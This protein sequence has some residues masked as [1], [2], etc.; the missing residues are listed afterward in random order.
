MEAVRAVADV[1]RAAPP[2]MH[3]AE[4]PIPAA[5]DPRGPCAPMVNTQTEEVPP[6][7]PLNA[8]QFTSFDGSAS[9]AQPAVPPAQPVAPTRD[10]HVPVSSPEADG[11]GVHAV[12]IGATERAP[13][14][15]GDVQCNVPASVAPAAALTDA[16][17][18]ERLAGR[19]ES[20][21]Q[22]DAHVPNDT[23]AQEHAAA[24]D[25]SETQ[26]LTVVLNSSVTHEVAAT[27]LHPSGPGSSANRLCSWVSPTQATKCVSATLCWFVELFRGLNV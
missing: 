4:E 17:K 27:S 25:D 20:A 22:Q 2:A 16:V 9:I 19:K 12:Q 3:A 11:K 1:V 7:A 26:E 6:Q 8:T 5:L 23:A 10:P 13:S 14:A 24:V 18:Q 21:I 15:H